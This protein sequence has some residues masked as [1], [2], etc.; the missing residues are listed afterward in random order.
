MT[1]FSVKSNKKRTQFITTI[2]Q[3]PLGKVKSQ[4]DRTKQRQ[5]SKIG[6]EAYRTSLL[7]AFARA[8]MIAFFNPDMD[9]F[10]TLTYKANQLDPNQTLY[11]IKKLIKKEKYLH[12]QSKKT[13]THIKNQ[14]QTLKYLYVFERQK[15][16]AI[17]VHMMANRGFTTRE[18]QN[19]FPELVNWSHGFSSVLTIADFDNNFKPYLYLLKYMHKAQRIGKSFIHT[20][21][22]FDKIEAVDY[23]QYIERLNKENLLYQEDTTYTIGTRRRR[24]VKQYH[25]PPAHY[26]QPNKKG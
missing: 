13:N 11:D 6:S 26:N 9:Q 8:K 20:S 16:G 22:N 25:K 7:R 21:R 18:N 3:Y 15:R 23:S 2:T 19:G 17:H 12:M 14:Q 24:I 1:F 10:I 4:H 5:L